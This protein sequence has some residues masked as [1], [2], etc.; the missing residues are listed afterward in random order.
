MKAKQGPNKCDQ[1]VGVGVNEHRWEG[2]M[3]MRV[4]KRWGGLNMQM[5]E[6][7]NGYEQTQMHRHKQVEGG[8]QTK[9][10]GRG[11]HRQGWVKG[12]RGRNE[13]VGD[14]YAWGRDLLP[15]PFFLFFFLHL[16]T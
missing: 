1:A 15:L 4:G 16:T 12:G 13:Q 5:S 14:G 8:G 6:Q 10:D 9:A 2:W 3:W 11:E 7:G